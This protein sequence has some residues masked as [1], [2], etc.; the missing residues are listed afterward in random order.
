MDSTTTA[1]AAAVKEGRKGMR[2]R[3]TRSLGGRSMRLAVGDDAD[4]GDDDGED[5]SLLTLAAAA[6]IVLAKARPMDLVELAR[7][8]KPLPRSLSILA[9]SASM[10]CLHFRH[11]TLDSSGRDDCRWWL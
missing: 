10:Q 9:S 2:A 3:S 8:K 5:S 11:A 4:E 6:A 7:K 1:A